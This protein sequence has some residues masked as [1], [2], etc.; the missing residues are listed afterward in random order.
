MK[1]RLEE[2]EAKLNFKS[3]C[4]TVHTQTECD[5]N[6]LMSKCDDCVH[7]A[8]GEKALRWHHF[9][10]YNKGNPEVLKNYSC[11]KCYEIFYQKEELMI[12]IKSE[13]SAGVAVCK[14]YKEGN[15][16]FT[17]ETCWFLHTQGKNISKYKCNYCDHEVE[18][19]S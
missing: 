16:H 13:H 14:Y 18:S 4:D 10:V 11:N 1:D 5:A 2:L 9:H 3:S 12:H 17:S 6:D 19:K 8:N 15:C 7:T